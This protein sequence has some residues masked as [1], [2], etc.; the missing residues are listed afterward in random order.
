MVRCQEVSVKFK[1]RNLHQQII[2][3]KAVTGAECLSITVN[4]MFVNITFVN[5]VF[6]LKPFKIISFA[7]ADVHE[8]MFESGIEVDEK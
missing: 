4:D 1:D 8:V 5:K 2:T 3:A 7:L 6:P